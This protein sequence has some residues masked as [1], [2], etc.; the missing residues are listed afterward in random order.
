MLQTRSLLLAPSPVCLIYPLMMTGS[1][2]APLRLRLLYF[3]RCTQFTGCMMVQ[4]ISFYLLSITK[5]VTEYLWKIILWIEIVGGITESHEKAAINVIEVLFPGAV[6]QGCFFH[7]CQCLNW[8]ICSCGLKKEFESNDEFAFKMRM[9][10]ALLFVPIANVEESFKILI[11]N[12]T[13]PSSANAVI[14][15][16]EDTCI[17]RPQRRKRRAPQ[18][19]ISLWNCF[20]RVL[21][22]MP[23]TNNAVEGWYH[24]FEILVG[25]SHVNMFRFIDWFKRKQV[26]TVVEWD[27]KMAG[28]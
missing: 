19:P 15:Y 4:Y 3:T 2:M 7:L 27:K 12:Q 8:Q 25:A 18:F 1:W 9:L 21:T 6:S 5:Q 14:D 10:V 26:L 22:D 23:K 20:N 28:E 24:G 13:F 11:D 16:F 17:R